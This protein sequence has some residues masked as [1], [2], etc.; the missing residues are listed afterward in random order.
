MKVV[1]EI[2]SINE[3]AT[4]AEKFLE[5]F[6]TPKCFAF[7]GDMGAGKTT[8]IHSIL[9]K[10]NIHHFEG[11]P[12]FAII[13]EYQNSTHDKIYHMDCYRLNSI[14]EAVDIG[15][16][17]ILDEKSYI[18]IEWAEKIEQLLPKD[19]IWVYIRS[20]D[21]FTREISFEYDN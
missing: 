11:S 6:P 2:N 1:W 19:I 18:F 4:Y 9:N 12:T 16:E 14:R 17:D 21:D 5:L 13:H 3:L 15:L 7:E 10:M 8:F 20:N